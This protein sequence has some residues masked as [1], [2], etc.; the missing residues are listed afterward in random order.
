[1]MDDDLASRPCSWLSPQGPESDVVLST[2]VRLARNLGDW[3]MP[4]RL[5][6]EEKSDL[7]DLIAGKLEDAA[8]VPDASMERIDQL[9]NLKRDVLVE[10]HVISRELAQGD[11]ARGVLFSRS[12][13]SSVMALEEDH[14]RLQAIRRGLQLESTW[15]AVDLLDDAL[16]D[17]FDYAVS[18]EF[19]YLTACP[20]NVGTGLRVSVMTHLPTLVETGQIPK[21]KTAASRVGLVLRG[22]R[23]EGS[24][25]QGD[26]FQIS[27]QVTFGKSEEDIIRLVQSMA[28]KI[29]EWERGVRRLLVEQDRTAVENR[30]WRAWGALQHAR[31]MSSEEAMEKLSL[32]R[33]GVNTKLLVHLTL[34][35]LNELFLYIQPGH[36]RTLTGAGE[37]P[38][39]RDEMRARLIRQYL[40]DRAR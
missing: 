35:D 32:I 14:L 4:W 21:V 16:E 20:T 30:V 37:E 31:I 3:R 8:P 17:V 26:F 11:G 19:G 9:P 15:R 22:F 25:S 12:E 2:R 6:A 34:G 18:E 5:S 29:V 23:G 39:D 27:T 10:R 36:I 1:M 33:L 7:Y 28:G 38:R 24:K 40:A 13:D